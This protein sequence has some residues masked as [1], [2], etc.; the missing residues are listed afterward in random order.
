M[1]TVDPPLI[2]R[3]RQS[4]CSKP[5]HQANG[6]RLRRTH[7]SVDFLGTTLLK[8][9]LIIL[10]RATR[11]ANVF[12]FSR[13]PWT[14]NSGVS[15]ESL[16]PVLQL[17]DSFPLPLPQR[18][19]QLRERKVCHLVFDSS[20]SPGRRGSCLSVVV[21]FLDSSSSTSCSS[22]RRSALLDTSTGAGLSSSSFPSALVVP[23]SFPAPTTLHHAC[24][25]KPDVLRPS[26]SNSLL[27]ARP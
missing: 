7:S 25:L 11:F 23:P 14:Y 15:A 19:H 17:C 10:S 16:V 3:P 27:P 9:A 6:M 20:C 4:N 26:S 5:R 18:L 1:I 21:L 22:P 13:H 12:P 8:T 24:R 2:A